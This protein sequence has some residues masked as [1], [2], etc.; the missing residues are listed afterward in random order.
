MRNTLIAYLDI[1]ARPGVILASGLLTL[2][3]TAVFGI[4]M[5]VWEFAIIDEMVRPDAVAAHVEAMTDAQRRAH[6]WLTGTVDLLY[7]FAYATFFTGV[8]QRFLSGTPRLILTAMA[9]AIVPFDLLEGLAQIMILGGKPAWLAVKAVATPVKLALYA[10]ALLM[11]TITLIFAG[12]RH[13]LR[14]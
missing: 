3:L 7:P 13:V 1:A 8:F 14:G 2:V 6:Q 4:V 10:P 9:I 11:A 12:F 5:S